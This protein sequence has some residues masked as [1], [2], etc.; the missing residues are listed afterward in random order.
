MTRT[1]DMVVAVG[2]PNFVPG[3]WLKPGA[4]VIDAGYNDGTIGDVAVDEAVAKASPITPGPGGVGATT[5]AMLI[6]PTVLA[7]EQRAR[8]AGRWSSAV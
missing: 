2:Q 6:Q 3:D 5:I 1:V 8:S 7:V 4:V